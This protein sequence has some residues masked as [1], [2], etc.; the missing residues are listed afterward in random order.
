MNRFYKVLFCLT[1]AVNFTFF[2]YSLDTNDVIKKSGCTKF[3]FIFNGNFE[4]ENSDK[5][6][7]ASS[8]SYL[9]KI[10]LNSWNSGLKIEMPFFAL[11]SY[12][13]FKK[14]ASNIGFKIFTGKL[15]PSLPVTF[16]AG[17]IGSSGIVSKVSN[18]QLSATS[19][20]YSAGKQEASGIRFSLPSSVSFS[21]PFSYGIS[22]GISRKKGFF[23]NTTLDFFYTPDQKAQGSV[24]T[25]ISPSPFCNIASTFYF[26]LFPIEEN[27]FSSWFSASE[28]YYHSDKIFSF[29][30]AVSFNYR[31]S[32]LFVMSN[33]YEKPEGGFNQI[34]RLDSSITVNNS[35][36][37]LAF[38]Y[39][40]ADKINTG[41]DSKINKSLQI[42]IGGTGKSLLALNKSSEP[43]FIKTG[44]NVFDSI[45]LNSYENKL[46]L[47][48]GVQLSSAFFITGLNLSLSASFEAEKLCFSGGNLQLNTK[49]VFL[50][51]NPCINA[52]CSFNPD[53]NYSIWTIN[54]KYSF[55]IAFKNSSGFSFSLP[56][57][58]SF[59]S[60]NLELNSWKG[61]ASCQ[62]N[63]STK[64][65]N[66]LLKL[67][68]SFSG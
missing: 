51:C 29:G 19:S 37:N 62:L 24:F 41:N 65:I 25:E 15:K 39:N 34:F 52:S 55:S 54:Q 20:P 28:H 13:E 2:I 48:S 12:T 42:R 45:N 30:S 68:V 26:S 61:T 49:L 46:K 59:S 16:Y 14:P 6:Q 53:K 8:E 31:K 38:F 64:Y 58:I 27:I 32:C 33:W 67:S 11:N 63:Y 47:L 66:Y 10:I 50:H 5:N 17:N 35:N 9:E 21:R 44:I 57:S 4:S 7:S 18:P 40:P 43:V 60:K 36:L 22:T 23:R 56:A 1:L 3:S